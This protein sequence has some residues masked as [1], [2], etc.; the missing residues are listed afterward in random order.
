MNIS[1]KPMTKELARQYY[2]EFVADPDLFAD[3]ESY[4]PYGYDEKGADDRYDRNKIV[5]NRNS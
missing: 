1:P 2:K 3:P 5:E 4:K